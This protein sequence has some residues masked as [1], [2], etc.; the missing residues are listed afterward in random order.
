MTLDETIITV[1]ETI[2]QV[3]PTL[4]TL[5]IFS[6]KI[7]FPITE[8]QMGFVVPYLAELAASDVVRNF[9]DKIQN[10]QKRGDQSLALALYGHDLISELLSGYLT[11]DIFRR[12]PQLNISRTKA[13]KTLTSVAVLYQFT[14]TMGY[15]A[16]HG[17]PQY[18]SYFPCEQLPFLLE[19]SF[20]HGGDIHSMV[21]GNVTNL[22]YVALHEIIKNAPT[23]WE[24]Y[25]TTDST[26]VQYIIQDFGS[27]IRHKDGRPLTANEI[28]KIFESFTTKGSG[29]GLRVARDLIH[30]LG[31]Y[32]EVAT[33]TEK[34]TVKCSTQNTMAFECPPS[35]LQGTSFTVYVP[36]VPA[37]A[38]SPEDQMA[39]N[40]HNAAPRPEIISAS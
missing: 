16:S 18:I 20:A 35:G 39:P 23:R 24:F 10:L 32:I 40:L 33:T 19:S 34:G 31:G 1:D 29:L 3:L 38:Q 22:E 11:L 6:R 30:S 2:L 13:Q 36:R 37:A 27:G 12:N 26:S 7:F 8:Q 28:P 9:T 17:D 4:H 5:D 14:R 25:I 15:F 21:A